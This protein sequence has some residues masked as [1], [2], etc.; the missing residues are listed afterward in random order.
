MAFHLNIG[1][2]L[3]P[4]FANVTLT[5]NPK[6]IVVSSV[7]AY[8]E[9]VVELMIGSVQAAN[10]N[11]GADI[12]NLIQW[13]IGVVYDAANSD[14]IYYGIGYAQNLRDYPAITANMLK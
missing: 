9:K 8:A 7:G 6:I 12:Y 4:T 5:Y 14:I 3:T 2:D 11:A 13:D 10:A 1:K